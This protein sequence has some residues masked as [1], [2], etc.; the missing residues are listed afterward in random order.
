M[1]V[2]CTLKGTIVIILNIT[3][4]TSNLEEEDP[5]LVGI[6]GTCLM[7]GDVDKLV[8]IVS[9]NINDWRR[10]TLKVKILINSS[11]F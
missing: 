5:P 3:P 2:G 4:F 6:M 11:W 9:T 8:G 1:E 7:F 10:H